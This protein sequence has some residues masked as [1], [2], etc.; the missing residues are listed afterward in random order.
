MTSPDDVT[1][2]R[3][4]IAMII[5][6]TLAV[7]YSVALARPILLPLVLAFLCKLALRPGLSWLERRGMTTVFAALLVMMG[8]V[9]C[10]GYG[11]YRLSD[12]AAAWIERLPDDLRRAR[13]RL[14][15]AGG[16]VSVQLKNVKEVS[17]VVADMGKVG[18]GSEPLE[19]AV[20]NQ[21]PAFALL[22]GV[23][24]VAASIG[25]VLVLTFFMLTTR[26]AFLSKIIDSTS[27]RERGLAVVSLAR[28]IE[29]SLTRYMFSIVVINVALGACVAL[30]CAATGLPNAILWGVVAAIAN[31]VPYVGALVGICLLAVVG[32]STYPTVA[33]GLMPA[34]LYA[35]L[36]VVEGAV[37]TP[38]IVGHRL[39]LSPVVLFVWLLLLG[40]LWGIPGA[41]IAVPL[42]VVC[43]VTCEHLP[44]LQWLAR[45]LET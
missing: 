37:I 40:W 11:M 38:I 6:A 23:W 20:V 28:S 10:G 33:S 16:G 31:F 43:K 8:V 34:G 13:D 14:F 45:F 36:T 27:S 32:L 26:G 25:I 7:T 9:A 12:P 4:S 35:I 44:R 42:L 2:R 29:A 3:S 21:R 1:Q 30:I 24:E 18:P 19:V 5:L 39:K 15:D 41:L 17:D 22:G